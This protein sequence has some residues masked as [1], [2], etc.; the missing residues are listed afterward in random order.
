M[1]AKKLK[2]ALQQMAEEGVVQVFRP[3][4]GSPA[5][6]GVVGPLQLDVLRVRAD[7]RIWPR[8][9]LGPEPEFSARA[10]DRADG[11]ATQARDIRSFE[12]FDRVA[13]DLDGDPRVPSRATSSSSDYTRERAPGDRRSPD[14]KDVKD[15]GRCSRSGGLPL[16]CDTASLR[17]S[18]AIQLLSRLLRRCAPRNDALAVCWARSRACGHFNSPSHRPP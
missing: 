16:C 12:L 13:E 7:G 11:R 1:K 4:D 9:R 15:V 5:L 18:E 14:I 2:E 10:L 17:V 3:H 8:N 6:V